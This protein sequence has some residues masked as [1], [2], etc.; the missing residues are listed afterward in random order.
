MMHLKNRSFRYLLPVLLFFFLAFAAF[1]PAACFGT[2]IKTKIVP[3]IDTETIGRKR[4]GFLFVPFPIY[5][6]ET[7][8]ALILT[9]MYHFRETETSYPSTLMGFLAYS[10]L[11]QFRTAGISQL[12]LADGMAHATISV[13]FA[14]WPDKFFGIGTDNT[15][16][17][18]EDF[19]SE[20]VD[21]RLALQYC[22]NGRLKA[23]LNTEFRNYEIT[24]TESGRM[25]DS[26]DIRGAKGGD[27][28]GI[29]PIATWDS[30]DDSFFPR[31]GFWGQVSALMFL[32]SPGD[33]E[34]QRYRLD[35]RQY[36]PIGEQGVIAFQEYINIVR[37][38]IPFLF[39]SKIGDLSRFSL[40]RGY[41]SGF[42]RE[43]DVAAMQVEYR[44]PLWKKLG[45]AVFGGAG[46]IGPDLPRGRD[47]AVKPAGGVGLRY[48][49]GGG[50]AINLRLDFAVGKD[51][52]GIYF[53]ILESF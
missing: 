8:A 48:R 18:E 6:P 37:G 31:K 35:M 46:A 19:T 10:Q 52:T 30:R 15:K 14:N 13:G 50:E 38:D 41:F 51:S 34:F 12:Y 40:L 47:L 24:K 22:I 16:D 5:T 4:S 25:L 28:F 36:M 44:T 21:L 23:G 33:Y 9:A 39:L 42:F 7:K 17:D 20:S 3:E 1:R 53:N 26:S 11:N 32:D 43:K 2:E 45:G 49:V 29:G 27:V